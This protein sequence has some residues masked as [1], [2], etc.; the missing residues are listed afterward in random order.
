M[1]HDHIGTQR[2]RQPAHYRRT[3]YRVSIGPSK[4]CGKAS[5]TRRQQQSI[6]CAT[7]CGL[8]E[9][10]YLH[11]ERNDVNNTKETSLVPR[12]SYHSLETHTPRQPAEEQPTWA[13]EHQC[14]VGL[15]DFSNRDC[16][17]ISQHYR[18]NQPAD[19]K[20]R[21]GIEI[22]ISMSAPSR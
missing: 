18:R 8:V 10:S 14:S 4:A 6:L 9:T 11:G 15:S 16:K 7:A 17:R 5:G 2:L 22:A 19:Q 12:D 13:T 3:N 20:R 1:Q 21:V